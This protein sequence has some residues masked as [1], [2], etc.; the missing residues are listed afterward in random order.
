MGV[1]GCSSPCWVCN[2]LEHKIVIKESD[3]KII[4]MRTILILLT[5]CIFKANVDA[6]ETQ[7][8][9]AKEG[10]CRGKEQAREGAEVTVDYDGYLQDRRGKTGK[11]FTST[12]SLSDPFSF[13]IGKKRSDTGFGAGVNW[14][15]CWFSTS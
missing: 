15:L 10:S 7:V 3:S 2:Q 5:L 13:T 11:K 8:D 6:A 9:V 14:V 12:Y 1:Q 4:R